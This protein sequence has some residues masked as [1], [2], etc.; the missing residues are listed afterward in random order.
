MRSTPEPSV[1]NGLFSDHFVPFF[2]HLTTLLQKLCNKQLS[3][4][5]RTKFKYFII[6]GS[7]TEGHLHEC[8]KVQQ[9]DNK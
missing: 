5:I 2:N 9:Q 4:C 1:E 3:Q 6:T 8:D 7:F